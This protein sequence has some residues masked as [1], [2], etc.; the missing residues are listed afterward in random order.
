MTLKRA[1]LNFWITVLIV[2]G[3]LGFLG[4][5][6][7]NAYY[8]G[9]LK[10]EGVTTWGEITAVTETLVRHAPAYRISYRFSVD[11]DKVTGSALITNVAFEDG[12]R[13][14][15]DL[16]ILYVPSNPGVNCPVMDCGLENSWVGIVLVLIVVAVM[17]LYLLV[18]W[19][20]LQKARNS[21]KE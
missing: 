7:R 4:V 15:E 6:V 11:G 17:G 10:A 5:Q 18:A 3:V 21:L 20:N 14:G 19:D 8:G 2:L 13:V 1:E 9:R 16:K 12:F